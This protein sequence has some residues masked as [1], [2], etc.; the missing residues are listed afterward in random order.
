[1]EHARDATPSFVSSIGRFL[2]ASPLLS[3]RGLKNRETS[4]EAAL[5]IPKRIA[6]IS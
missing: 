3:I 4:F 5:S 2:I 6:L 1:V